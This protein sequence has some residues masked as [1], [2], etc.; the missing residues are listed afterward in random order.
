MKLD[1]SPHPG[2]AN[3]AAMLRAQATM[4]L[5]L[6]MRNGE[7]LLLT[8]VIPLMLLIAGTRSDRIVDLGPGR[9][10]DIVAPGVFALAILSTAFTSLAIATGFERRYGVLKRLGASPLSPS[11]LLVGKFAAV[12]VV[13]IAQLTV[14]GGIALLLGWDPVSALSVWFFAVLVALLGTAAFGSL[15]ML[16]AGTLRAEATLAI[17]NLVYVVLL[18]GGAVLVPLARYP[19]SAQ[20]IISLLPS[21]ALGEGFRQTFESG[22][23][24]WLPVIVLTAWSCV[25]GGLAVKCFRWE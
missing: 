22:A 21:A 7:Q 15:A 8:V 14:L 19:E 25:A 11:G 24:G 13:V 12:A 1:L 9:P 23:P 3:R 17:A 16:I 18:V 6:L 10:I 2:S 5:K 4:E 20:G